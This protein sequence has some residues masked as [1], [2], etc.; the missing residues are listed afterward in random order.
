M[1]TA[2]KVKA[3]LFLVVNVVAS[4]FIVMVNKLAFIAG[5]RYVCMLTVFH[6]IS[7]ALVSLLRPSTSKLAIEKAAYPITHTDALLYAVFFN[8]SIVP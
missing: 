6:Q 8:M 2:S 4:L 3:S 7:T 1:T 5:F